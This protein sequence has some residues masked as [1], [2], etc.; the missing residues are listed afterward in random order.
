M[1]Y[2]RKTNFT[3]QCDSWLFGQ[4]LFRRVFLSLVALGNSTE[5]VVA[6][7]RRSRTS[8]L[9]NP[10]M[11]TLRTTK[12]AFRASPYHSTDGD[13]AATLQLD[14]EGHCPIILLGMVWNVRLRNKR[15]DVRLHRVVLSP[16]SD[17]SRLRR[18]QPQR[19]TCVEEQPPSEFL[20]CD[21]QRETASA[22]GRSLSSE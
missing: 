21:N 13:T 1:R 10:S 5:S 20:C 11:D 8:N 19:Y 18:K 17:F 4:R 3:Q 7:A 15:K 14:S 2:A 9:P 22:T 12:L 6:T 16:N